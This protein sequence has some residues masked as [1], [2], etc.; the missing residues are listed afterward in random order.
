M[1]RCGIYRP[2]GQRC[3]LDAMHSS[4]CRFVEDSEPLEKLAVLIAALLSVGRDMDG[5]RPDY[6]TLGE[7][8][9]ELFRP[10]MERLSDDF[11]VLP[12][13]MGLVTVTHISRPSM[14]AVGM[15]ST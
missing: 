3:M 1:R 10:H 7:Q 14:L 8:E 15:I 4:P 12:T 9:W 2:D 11:Y 6:I 5:R 13:L